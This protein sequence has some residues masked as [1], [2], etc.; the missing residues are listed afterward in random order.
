MAKAFHK[1]SADVGHRREE[2]NTNE[3]LSWDGMAGGGI[4]QQ[5]ENYEFPNPGN[6]G[7][8]N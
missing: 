1:N 2:A 7:V 3:E 4:S 6:A 5:H 8:P